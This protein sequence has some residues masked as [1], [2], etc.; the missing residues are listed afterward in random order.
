[1]K[2]NKKIH[3]LLNN[4]DFYLRKNIKFSRKGLKIANEDKNKLF[5]DGNLIVKEDEYNNEYNLKKIKNNSTKRNYLETL[6]TI[7]ILKKTFNLN[8]IKES[9][10]ILDIG[11]KNWFYAQGEYSYF[12]KHIKN[13]ELTGVELD[14]YRVYAD[15]YSRKDYAEYYI[16]NL[17]NTKY[18]VDNLMNINEEYDYITWFLPFVAEAPLINWGLPLSEFQPEILLKKAYSLLK[19]NGKMLIVN[20]GISEFEIQKDLLNKLSIPY[21]EIGKIESDF[22]EYQNERFAIIVQK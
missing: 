13:I 18:L 10:K 14:G 19:P 6:Y 4:L 3:N 7:D 20:Q 22:L 8:S 12:A 2:K 9:A 11:S 1:M 5:S 15:F 17:K 16:K 21:D